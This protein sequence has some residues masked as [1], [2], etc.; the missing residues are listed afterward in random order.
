MPNT[1]AHFAINGLFSRAVVRDA[2]LK[3]VYLACVI[4]DIPWILQRLAKMLPLTL[5]LYDLRAYCIAQSSFLL[6][7]ILCVA[8]AALAKQY[9]KVFVIL[10]LG[11]LLHLLVDAIQIKWANGV[12][13]LAPIDWQLI[14]FD[15]FWPESIGTYTLTAA[16]FAYLVFNLKKVIRPNCGEFLLSIKT[17]SIFLVFAL[18]WLSLPVVFISTVYQAN[19]H[20]ISTLKDVDSRSGKPIEIDRNT[21]HVNSSKHELE[22]SYGEKIGLENFHQFQA[23]S[24]SKVSLQGIFIDNHTIQVENFHIHSRFRD[25]ASMLGLA[26]VFLIWLIF[27]VRCSARGFKAV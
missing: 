14:R 20:F 11:C 2:D 17:L 12:N 9:I 22:T 15:L 6:C 19:N 24:D 27:I 16:G 26:C 1:I 21:Y 23:K 8:L 25:Y 10:I 4:P 18:I 5:D 7:V 3:W 13:L